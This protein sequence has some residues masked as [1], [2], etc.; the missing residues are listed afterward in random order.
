MKKTIMVISTFLSAFAFTQVNYQAVSE[1][2]RSHSALISEEDLF[3]KGEITDINN[4]N[5]FL[6]LSSINNNDNNYA[7]NTNEEKQKEWAEFRK[8][9][10]SSYKNNIA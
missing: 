7:S 2:T 6:P 8:E 3:L 9:E 5:S 10:D 1:P 4:S